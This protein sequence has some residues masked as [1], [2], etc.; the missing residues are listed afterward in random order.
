ML[1]ACWESSQLHDSHP[2]NLIIQNSRGTDESLILDPSSGFDIKQIDKYVKAL[3]GHTLLWDL[4]GNFYQSQ[5]LTG[6]KIFL[7]KRIIF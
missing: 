5:R 7:S 1:R 6:Q 4:R 3:L 2:S